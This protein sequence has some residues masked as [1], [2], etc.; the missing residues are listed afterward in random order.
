MRP[1]GRASHSERSPA[2]ARRR[3]QEQPS[4]GTPS[5][6]SRSE[7]IATTAAS[8]A[9][10]LPNV[11]TGTLAPGTPP[12]HDGQRALHPC[13]RAALARGPHPGRGRARG[14]M[15]FDSRTGPLVWPPGTTRAACRRQT[16]EHKAVALHAP[17][18]IGSGLSSRAPVRST[19][20]S[21][22][23][24]QPSAL[25]PSSPAAT[26]SAIRAPTCMSSG[27]PKS[28]VCSRPVRSM[29]TRVGVPRMP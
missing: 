9:P 16:L 10:E 25:Q 4:P 28:C 27:R 2:L 19:S 11:P 22:W 5:L 26:S 17:H 24:V 29:S 3:T 8:G 13:T 1:S 20:Y 12:I 23:I 15:S 14:R 21:S 18:S 7:R 6:S